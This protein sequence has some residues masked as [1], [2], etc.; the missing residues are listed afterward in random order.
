MR[1]VTA[2]TGGWTTYQIGLIVGTLLELLARVTPS[3]N[4]FLAGLEDVICR[5]PSPQKEG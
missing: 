3:A 4:N 2:E 5:I 1:E